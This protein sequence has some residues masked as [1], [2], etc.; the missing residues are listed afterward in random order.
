MVKFLLFLIPYSNVDTVHKLVDILHHMAG[1]EAQFCGIC[2]ALKWNM[3]INDT[4]MESPYKMLL[5]SGLKL[6]FYPN[7]AAT[8]FGT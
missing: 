8:P 1:L 7:W 2:T 4:S 5:E 3:V 6:A